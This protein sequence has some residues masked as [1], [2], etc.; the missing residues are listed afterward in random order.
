MQGSGYLTNGRVLWAKVATIP[1]NWLFLIFQVSSSYTDIDFNFF[2]QRFHTE[3]FL[4]L[5]SNIWYG[6]YSTAE[7]IPHTHTHTHTSTLYRSAHCGYHRYLTK[8]YVANALVSAID[9]QEQ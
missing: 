9:G 8:I 4:I 7:N 3:N 6:F 1:N 5:L 2:H